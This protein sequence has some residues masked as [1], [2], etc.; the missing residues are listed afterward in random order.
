MR[1]ILAVSTDPKLLKKIEAGLAYLD[2]EI[3][4]LSDPDKIFTEI[5]TIKPDM[6]IVDFI[7]SDSNGGAICHQ[8]KCN[9]ATHNMP[10]IIISE[11]DDIARFAN[12]FGSNAIV[13]KQM[14][15]PYLLEKVLDIWRENLTPAF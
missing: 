1:K 4:Q 14:V 12:K 10:V 6:L 13:K 15:I 7:L 5:E 3:H 9:P 2:F 11:Y 8:V